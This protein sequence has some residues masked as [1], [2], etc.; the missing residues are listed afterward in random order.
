MTVASASGAPKSLS[1][2]RRQLSYMPQDDILYMQ[3]TVRQ[4]L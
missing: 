2:M 1:G 4:L 3:L